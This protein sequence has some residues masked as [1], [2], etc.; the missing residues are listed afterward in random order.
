M[1]TR[2]TFFS[3]VFSSLVVVAFLLS[4]A[5]NARQFRKSELLARQ[6]EAAKR[7]K[8]PFVGRIESSGG[9]QNIT[10]SN[11]KASRTSK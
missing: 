4:S 7:W 10:F 1:G 8:G 5:V 9:V 6:L 3:T 11:P 2:S